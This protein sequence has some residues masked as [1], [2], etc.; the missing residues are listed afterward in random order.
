MFLL[1]V[2]DQL[3]EGGLAEYRSVAVRDSLQSQDL[4]VE[5]EKEGLKKCREEWEKGFEEVVR[6]VH[7]EGVDYEELLEEDNEERGQGLS[8][9]SVQGDFIDCLSQT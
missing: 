1:Q 5:K 2:V 3:K 8:S 9:S 7:E 6:R 4:L